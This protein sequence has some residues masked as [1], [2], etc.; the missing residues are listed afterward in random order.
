MSINCCNSFPPVWRKDAEI[1]ILGS[2]PGVESLRQQ[3]YYAFPRNAF[4]RIMGDL[5]QFDAQLSYPERLEH[6]RNNHL[7][8]WDVLQACERQGSLDSNIQHAKPNDIP[9]LLEQCPGLRKI[10]CN[11][12]A[13]AAHFIRFFPT[14]A[15]R[16]VQLPS[17]SP[18][19]A[20]WSY[21]QKLSAWSVIIQ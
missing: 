7:A 12:S 17:T 18:A 4:W 6:L 10:Y 13:A 5:F 3:Q 20:K 11:G 21:E 19:A 16:M 8:L 2:M 1:L 9:W 14:Q 15:K